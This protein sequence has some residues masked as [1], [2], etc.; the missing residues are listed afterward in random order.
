MGVHDGTLVRI[1]HD[2][3]GTQITYTP[4]GVGYQ[5]GPYIPSDTPCLVS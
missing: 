1:Q 4:S 2:A 3:T 5:L